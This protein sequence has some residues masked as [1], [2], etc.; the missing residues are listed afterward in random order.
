[1]FRV[2]HSINIPFPVIVYAGPRN[3]KLHL[4]EEGSTLGTTAGDIFDKRP[5]HWPAAHTHLET[6][7][8]LRRIDFLFIAGGHC[9]I[10][11]DGSG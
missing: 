4:E 3:P 8:F 10:I 5:P 9:Y 6:Q 2:F 7:C 11:K 1:L